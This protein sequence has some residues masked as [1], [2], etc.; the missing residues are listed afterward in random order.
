MLTGSD[1]TTH[2]E[3]QVVQIFPAEALKL[4][5][6]DYIGDGTAPLLLLDL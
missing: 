1:T 2:H 3:D 4:V 6:L 5:I